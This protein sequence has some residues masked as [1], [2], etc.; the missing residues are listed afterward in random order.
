MEE[1]AQSEKIKK[2]Y[3]RNRIPLS[4]NNCRRKK[5]K[6]DRRKPTCKVC[7]AHNLN[8]CQYYQE[9]IQLG[10]ASIKTFCSSKKSDKSHVKKSQYLEQLKHLNDKIEKLERIL[11]VKETKKITSTP[12][13]HTID[14]SKSISPQSTTDF[15]ITYHKPENLEEHRLDLKQLFTSL[16]INS[17]DKIH[18]YERLD[19]KITQYSTLGNF[20][21]FAWATIIMK[22]PFTTPLWKQVIIEQK[23]IKSTFNKKPISVKSELITI[24]KEKH[25]VFFEAESDNYKSKEEKTSLLQKII[26]ILPSK[27]MTWL[28]IE[29]FFNLIYPFIP[30]I[31]EFDFVADIERIICGNHIADLNNDGPINH[32]NLPQHTD[33]AI[34]GSLLIVIMFAYESLLDNT[35]NFVIT[36]NTTDTEKYLA[37]Y[38]HSQYLIPFSELCMNEF[39]LL[40]RCQL[41]VLQCAIL[42]REYQRVDGCDCF[43]DGDSHIY[44]GLLI[45]MATT[46]GLNRDPEFVE[47]DTVQSR[48][49]LLLR[50]IWYGLVSA[51]NHQYMQTGA[52]PL[53]HPNYYDTK[54]PLFDEKTTNIRNI[55]LERVTIEMMRCRY[56]VE[57]KM[58]EIADL[59]SNMLKS[60][61]VSELLIKIFNLKVF[62]SENLGSLNDILGKNHENK[63]HKKVQKVLAFMIYIHAMTLLQPV[64][65]HIFYN[66]Q[67]LRNFNAT[68]FF[69]NK[70]H[71]F[72]MYIIANLQ[73]LV[74]ESELFF[75][76]G[77]DIFVVPILEVAMHKGLVFFS[78][79]YIKVLIVEKKLKRV[80]GDNKELQDMIDV[81]K[82]NIL[83]KLF[84]ELYLPLLQ[85]LSKKYF[86]SWRLYKAH[87]TL[88][89]NLKNDTIDY[90]E[91]YPLFNFMEY[92][93]ADHFRIL[94]QTTTW[95]YY[96]FETDQIPLWIIDWIKNYD[97]YI[98][99]IPR[100]E[101]LIN[102]RSIYSNES[103]YSDTS[104]ADGITNDLSYID[105]KWLNK[106]YEKV[107]LNNKQTYLG[108]QTSD[109]ALSTPD[110]DNTITNPSINSAG[111]EMDTINSLMEANENMNLVSPLDLK[112]EELFWMS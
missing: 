84:S 36:E 55:K 3:K 71:S 60:P 13:P 65:L 51:D 58:R 112:F 30:Y 46:I 102:N 89:R 14:Q 42:L 70:I 17:S 57:I 85:H 75:G 24:S 63:H 45:Q 80:P 27:K 92:F 64:F 35:G 6:C 77:F 38:K 74:K 33:L 67:K 83:Q 53:I 10:T 32:I 78:S 15:T 103:L 12:T 108:D 20:G 62:L 49:S 56:F 41:S 47:Y 81:Y 16:Q 100:T 111:D 39:K 11:T 109:N 101:L 69:Y 5:T 8:N 82:K 95:K 37:T 4:C 34:L 1:N 86:Y 54:L 48:K 106:I 104:S 28:F 91:Q 107:F 88:F 50:K 98:Y 9:D 66:Y 19:P 72:W 99:Y 40:K 87:S 7:E 52:P 44:T 68:L 73:E 23:R 18:V 96:K 79:S 105:E 25:K 26:Q 43:A 22:D 59:A 97:N 90:T 93:T 31:D 94:I 21:P 2:V 29:R 110:F 61:S 76:F